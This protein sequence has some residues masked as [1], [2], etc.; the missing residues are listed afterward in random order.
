[1]KEI[2]NYTRRCV[3]IA[4][5]Y[6]MAL[7]SFAQEQML[8]V[9]SHNDY[10]REN[11]LYNAWDAGVQSVEADVHI[12]NGRLYVSHIRPLFFR[13]S[14]TL[15]NLYLRPLF[16]EI[17][18]N[19]SNAN[20][21][22]S[23]EQPPF[24]LWIDIKS[25]FDSTYNVLLREIE[26][27]KTHLCRVKNEKIVW[28]SVMIILS[29]NRDIGKLEKE[30]IRWVFA[31]GRSHHLGRKY[32][33]HLMPVI[34]DHYDKIIKEGPKKVPQKELLTNWAQRVRKEGKWSR[35]WAAPDH[36]ESWK[37]QWEAGISFINTDQPALL[38]KIIT[39]TQS[40][41][42]STIKED[43]LPIPKAPE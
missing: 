16:T 10:S 25:D 40:H 37:R 11:P 2:R 42:N 33:F 19:E 23:K 34:S 6:S 38:A 20:N 29:G 24:L 43:A 7:M 26:P 21:A 15:E 31:D 30:S 35:L 28:G 3:L 27:Y 18:K 4:V 17:L 12:H 5:L 1:M 39:A 32:P 8:P 22:K 36:P 41:L 14:K 13:E 9:H